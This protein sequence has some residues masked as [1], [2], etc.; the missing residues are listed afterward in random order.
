ME[1]EGDTLLAKLLNVFYRTF[2]LSITVL[3]LHKHTQ[4]LNHPFRNYNPTERHPRFQM[5]QILLLKVNHRI[6]RYF[7]SPYLP[8]LLISVIEDYPLDPTAYTS[9][10]KYTPIINIAPKHIFPKIK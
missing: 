1:P 7:Y 5:E 9:I 3:T 4:S 6:Q 10:Q 8:F 2:R